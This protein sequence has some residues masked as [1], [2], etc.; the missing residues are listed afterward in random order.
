MGGETVNPF[1]CYNHKVGIWLNLMG[2]CN[3]ARI[4]REYL[5]CPGGKPEDIVSLSPV[6]RYILEF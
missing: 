1:N 5:Q 2:L 4:E 6:S 3:S